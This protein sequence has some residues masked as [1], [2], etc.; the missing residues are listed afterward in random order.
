MKKNAEKHYFSSSQNDP[1]EKNR[2]YE[3]ILILFKYF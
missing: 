3:P 2:M 1:V